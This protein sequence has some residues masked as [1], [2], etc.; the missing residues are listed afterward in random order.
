MSHLLPKLLTSLGLHANSNHE[1][2]RV[3]VAAFNSE[4]MLYS[5]LF[6]LSRIICCE[7]VIMRVGEG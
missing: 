7:Q 6:N 1:T 3:A 2:Q 5:N 4:V